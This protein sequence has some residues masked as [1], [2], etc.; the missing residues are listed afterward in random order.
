[1][2]L[3][4]EMLIKNSEGRGKLDRQLDVDMWTPKEKSKLEKKVSRH[5]K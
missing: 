3:K 5:G 1:M 2:T 4:F